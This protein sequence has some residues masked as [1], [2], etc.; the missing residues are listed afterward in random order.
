[1]SSSTF[2]SQSGERWQF[3]L[4]FRPRRTAVQV[5]GVPRKMATHCDFPVSHAC[6]KC[7]SV[8]C[9]YSGHTSNRSWPRTDAMWPQPA[10]TT[11]SWSTSNQEWSGASFWATRRL[12]VD[13]TSADSPLPPRCWTSPVGGNVT[14]RVTHD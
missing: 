5:Y 14:D 6:L 3:T 8:S 7:G 11:L 13:G 4:S 2:A 9:R 10:F 1:M 12:A